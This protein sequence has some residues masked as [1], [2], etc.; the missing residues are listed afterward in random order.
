MKGREEQQ[1][2]KQILGYLSLKHIFAWRQNS[3]V[4]IY[5]DGKKKRL[6]RCGTPGVSD[7]IGFYKNKAFFIE[8]KTKTGRLTKRQR[9]F[10]EAVNKNGQ[11]GVVLR[12]LKECVELFERWGRGESLESLRR[13]FR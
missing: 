7:I 6:I 5:Q 9:T 2:Q 1:I 11:L 3:G 8:V 12:D 4:F 13:K 10:L